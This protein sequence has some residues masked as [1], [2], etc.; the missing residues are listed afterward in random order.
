MICDGC[1]I[2]QCEISEAIVGVRTVV[3]RGARIL[4]SV[5]MGADGYE[6]DLP[7]QWGDPPLGI[8]RNCHI[9]GAILDKN[10]RIGDGVRISP[11]PPG[12]YEDHPFYFVRDGIVVIPKNYA[13]PAG[14]VI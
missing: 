2:H 6:G 14:A 10:A 8:G 11:K 1:Y 9:E 12:T 7:R 3:N 13:V 5:I 4:R